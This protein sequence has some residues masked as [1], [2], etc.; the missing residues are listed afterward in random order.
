MLKVANETSNVVLAKLKEEAKIFIVDMSTMDLLA[1][2][3]YMM[4]HDRI[5]RE[6]MAA[7]AAVVVAAMVAPMPM[8]PMME[9]PAMDQP[10][11]ME[12]Q[13]MTKLALVME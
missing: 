4:F 6:V 1:R 7:Q 5:G 11:V 2:A 3:L 10:P 13:P 12:E 9:K 8:T